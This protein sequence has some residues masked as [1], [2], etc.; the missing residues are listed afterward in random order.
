MSDCLA[1]R[2]FLFYTLPVGSRSRLRSY[3]ITA[4]N[5]FSY[6]STDFQQD[7]N[8]ASIKV[9]GELLRVTIK[10]PWFRPSLFENPSLFFVSSNVHNK[11]LII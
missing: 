11:K 5:H 10:R 3:S 4:A 9:S 7:L 2:S 6:G 8:R 1:A